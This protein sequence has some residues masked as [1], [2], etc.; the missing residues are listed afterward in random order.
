MYTYY[1]HYTHYTPAYLSMTGFTP[2]KLDNTSYSFLM[3]LLGVY[4]AL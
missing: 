3:D 4:N 1:I 2:E